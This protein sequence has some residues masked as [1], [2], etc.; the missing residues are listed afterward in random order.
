MY[1]SAVCF[2]SANEPQQRLAVTF[3]GS[4]LIPS[5]SVLNDPALHKVWK[6]TFCDAY[7]KAD[8]ESGLISEALRMAL[9]WWFQLEFPT[10][11]VGEDLS[12]NFQMK[13]SPKGYVD[14]LYLSER[15]R[16]TRGNRGTLVVVE[17]M[18]SHQL[19]FP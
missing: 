7:K 8:K 5:S 4:T 10:D 18:D 2:K 9:S 15:L 19:A 12:V 11:L 1:H 13:R 14:V 16:I 17:R 6:E 3:K